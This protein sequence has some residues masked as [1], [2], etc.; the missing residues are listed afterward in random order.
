MSKGKG[1][2]GLFD[3]ALGKAIYT[4]VR[5]DHVTP[6]LDM[7]PCELREAIAGIELRE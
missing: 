3:H 5:L 7:S 4:G 1:L 6:Y 2:E